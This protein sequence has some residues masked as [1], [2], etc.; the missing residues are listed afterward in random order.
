M[1]RWVYR[2][3]DTVAADRIQAE[4]NL[5][6][7]LAVLLAQR[8]V[9]EPSE[10]AG[11]LKPSLDQLHDPNRLR[12]M[13]E[14]VER[15]RRAIARAEKI[16]V[17]GDYDVDGTT[18]IVLLTKAI[19]LAGGVA[20][21]HVPHRVKE[22]YGMREE[23]VERAAADD[24]KVIISVD[25]GIRE[26][27]VVDR[28]R[29]LGIDTIITDHHLPDSELPAAFAV[30]NPNQPG[31]EYPDKGLCGVGIAFKLAQALLSG[32]GWTPGKLAKVLR[33]MLKIV[34]IGTIADMVPLVGEN[35][36]FAKLGLDGLRHPSNLG[37]TALL[38]VA[39]L[40]QKPPTAGDVGF[41]IG[42]R[43]NAAGRMDT[44]K[45]VV[46]LFTTTDAA[47][48]RATAERLDDLN[49]RRQQAEEQVVREIAKRLE[50]LPGP[51]V[52]PFIVVE[53][54]NWPAGVIGIVASRIVERFHRPT[55]VLSVD[56]ETGL[57]TGSGRSIPAFHLLE[58]LESAA[59]IFER[60]GGHKQAAG[61]TLK[62][63]RVPELR[64]LLNEHAVNLLGEEDFQPVIRID[65]E[66]ELAKIDDEFME[67]IS[68]LAPHGM[69]NPTPVFSSPDV[70]LV[71]NPR[72][73]K[74]RHLKVRLRQNGCSFHGM[75]WRMA[76]L[77]ETLDV[78]VPLE[79][80]YTVEAD[81]YFGG[82]RLNLRDLRPA[83]AL[84]VSAPA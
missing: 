38:E 67:R 68:S 52:V 60:F 74:E 40:R 7:L 49:S 83:A 21:Y 55:L 6:R 28:A 56:P 71:E 41:R 62:A 64:D 11:F 20:D 58:S 5:P 75:A 27:K 14:A 32:L 22:G 70:R 30:V 9:H 39:G 54:E 59:P 82:W 4:L 17:Y 2:E 81:D 72:V 43:I 65:A 73:I 26:H 77:A 25:T 42:P 1:N 8:G 69:G 10:V 3:Y 29:E 23:V 18:S 34:A 19:E 47:Q 48:A 46:E 44:A 61:C 76:E 78:G 63:E 31:C 53:G 12:G 33:S 51:D 36:V 24:V 37:L 79:S 35:R 66:L 80:A 13:R 57:A 84:A 15:V 45:S 16:L 50:D